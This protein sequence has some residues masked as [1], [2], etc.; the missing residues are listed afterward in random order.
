MVLTCIILAYGVC[1]FPTQTRLAFLPFLAN[2]TDLPVPT[3]SKLTWYPAVSLIYPRWHMD[4]KYIKLLFVS[5]CNAKT[6]SPKKLI[7]LYILLV[8]LATAFDTETNPGPQT[9]PGSPPHI[10]SPELPHPTPN[11]S[12]ESQKSN[13]ISHYPC[14]VC[15]QNVGWEEKGICCEQCSQWYHI[16]C[17]HMSSKSYDAMHTSDVVW[18]CAK[19]GCPNF[20]IT[21]FDSFASLD[22][23]PFWSLSDI[24]S[25]QY[26]PGSIRSISSPSL[27]TSP[28]NPQA[29]SS[30]NPNPRN[31][32]DQRRN[33]NHPP[34][35]LLIMNCQSIVNKKAELHAVID[36]SKPDI[37]LGTES[38]LSKDI[39][40]YSIFPPNFS[41]YRKDRL[42]GRI[43][44][45]V[46][47]AVS[48]KFISA[49]AT[50]LDTNCEA[51]WATVQ[52]VGYKTMYVGS[53]Y[54]PPGSSIENLSE[55]HTSLSRI[56]SLNGN[57]LL[58]GDFNVGHINWDSMSVIPTRDLQ[59]KA[60]ERSAHHKT[61]D[62]INDFS[63][64][65]VVDTPTTRNGTTLD[66]LLT[67]NASLVNRIDTM[68][69]LTKEC[70]HDIVFS[71][72]NLR[73]RVN[74]KKPRKIFLYAK[75]DW[76]KLKERIENFINEFVNSDHQNKPVEELW[77][78]FKAELNEAIN[79]YIPSKMSK[80]SQS[81][82]WITKRI[83]KLIAKRDK[84]YTKQRRSGKDSDR[85]HF[86]ELQKTVQKQIKQAYWSYIQDIVTL[87]PINPFAKQRRF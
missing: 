82:P 71:E 73:A 1:I 57:I 13:P 12:S 8:L 10:T 45:G 52:L 5:Y 68:P 54:R 9:R 66:L 75:G 58:G 20:S 55:L 63:L 17:E 81:F 43:G 84:Y 79:L 80:P 50:E 42:D 6:K 61:L 41:I 38:W 29:T 3:V 44:G 34:L 86:K 53:F 60:R 30:P 65:Q 31:K 69:G 85:K 49:E 46:F 32:P 22:T 78:S 21:L 33:K 67:N 39:D 87:D 36:T 16:Q 26:S 74:Y 47:I 23:N 35:R 62:L 18:V 48:D 76:D 40:T 51:V 70:V 11:H 4:F 24:S 64:E 72:V 59:G 37:I 77:S 83:K 2:T 56:A 25:A 27:L 7:F 15:N 28:G 14:G 19:C